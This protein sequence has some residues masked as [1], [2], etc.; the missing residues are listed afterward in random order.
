MTRYEC[1]KC[2]YKWEPKTNRV[3]PKCVYCSSTR[4]EPAR[5]AQELIDE[6]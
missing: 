4:I 2:N 6:L 1:Q 3:P 5:Q